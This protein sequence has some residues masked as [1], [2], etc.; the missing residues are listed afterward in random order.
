MSHLT[1]VV[2]GG[3]L[4]NRIDAEYYKPEYLE[5]IYFL[6]RVKKD[7]LFDVK[8]LKDMTL[9]IRKGIF[10][11]LASEYVE[12]GVPFLR[13]SNLKDPLLN[14]ADLVYISEE[15]NKEHIKTCLLPG[16]LAISKGGYLG[17]VSI[18]PPYIKK[19][20]ISQDVIGV[21]LRKEYIPEYVLCFLL[22]K[23]GQAQLKRCRTQVAQPHLELEYVRRLHVVLPFKRFQ[24][25]I[26][27]QIK[28]AEVFKER[29]KELHLRLEDLQ[30]ELG[31]VFS[32]IPKTCLTINEGDL[33][34]RLDPEFYYYKH[35]IP[36]VLQKYLYQ[37]RPF[38][39]VATLSKKRINPTKK[40]DR[41]IRYVEIA[42]VNPNTGE[43]EN[44]SEILG[45]KAPGRA[46]MIL[47]SGNIVLSSLKGSLRSI[48]I[49]PSELDNAIGTTGFF[50][51]E[52]NEEII[53]K[54]S[55]WWV[56]RT[57]VCQRQLEQIASGAIMPAIN[58]QE[59]KKLKIPIPPPNI[60]KEIKDKVQEI[61]KLRKE[62]NRLVIEAVR[63]VEELIESIK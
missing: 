13:V 21:K 34:S 57:D 58:E 38:D 16:D 46:R 10:Y 25:K 7:K 23:Y 12:K 33:V 56:L 62:A 19:C 26:K 49:V 52:P 37:V 8:T 51:I 47:K 31:L 35:E 36:K 45:A 4:E 41:K 39:D 50:V 44:W 59:L 60:Q 11:I 42:D 17:L 32:Q 20:N 43:I 9:A 40:P 15:K 3:D 14:E 30:R 24:Q 53:N 5:I 63:Q 54:E 61:Q 29:I 28:K 27:E 6:N 18:I 55:L 48:A 1:W 2:K 22:T